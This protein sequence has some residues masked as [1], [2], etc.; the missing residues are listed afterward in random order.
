MLVLEVQ[1]IVL[2]IEALGQCKWSVTLEITLWG[3]RLNLEWI[4][5]SIGDVV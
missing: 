1:N 2:E 4:V 3:E 5:R